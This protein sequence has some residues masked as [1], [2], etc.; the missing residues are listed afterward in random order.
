MVAAAPCRSKHSNRLSCYLVPLQTTLLL[1]TPPPPL[2]GRTGAT[3]AGVA[4]PAA[5]SGILPGQ[6]LHF[7]PL[8]KD[9]RSVTV[10][11]NTSAPGLLSGSTAK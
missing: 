3:A 6:A 8:G 2:L 4:A 10:R 9:S 5:A 11:L 1:A 7:S